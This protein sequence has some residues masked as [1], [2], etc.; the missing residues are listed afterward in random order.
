MPDPA[1]A[2]S[3]QS[4]PVLSDAVISFINTGSS[5]PTPAA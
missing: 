3:G 1:L 4:I 5:A 2:P